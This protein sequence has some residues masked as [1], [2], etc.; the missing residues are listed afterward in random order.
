MKVFRIL[1]IVA[2]AFFAFL[3]PTAAQAAPYGG[4]PG[5]VVVTPPTQSGNCV[6][7]SIKVTGPANTTLTL[8]VRDSSGKVVFK[9]SKNSGSK[10]QAT[11][12]VRVC[13]SGT[14]TAT[15]TGPGGAVLGTSQFQ[16]V[17]GSQGGGSS[18]GGTSPSSSNAGGL[19]STGA[20]ND[21][22][23]IGGAAA[24]LLVGGI[25]VAAAR[26]KSL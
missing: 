12:S 1:A 18:A 24:L 23:L 25:T 15:G 19:P 4:Q 10:G 26:R 6:V 3:A 13:G 17:S 20:P 22:L 5:G 7:T 9:K 16:G 2:F 11:F 8:T 14:F 21:T